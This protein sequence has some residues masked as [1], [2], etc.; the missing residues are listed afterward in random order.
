MIIYPAVDIKDGQCVRLKQGEFNQVK[1]YS[2]NPAEVALRWEAE[3]AQFL[4]VV[5]LDGA[6]SGQLKNLRAVEE[7]A[8]KVKI[9]FQLGGGIRNP[10][11]IKEAFEVG[12]SRIV[13]GTVLITQPELAKVVFKKYGSEKIVAG[14]DARRGKVAIKGW[15]EETEHQLLEIAKN[16][17]DLGI[18][19]LIFTDILSDGLQ[20]GLNLLAIENLA[21][22][23]KMFLIASGGVSSL[24]DIKALKNLEPLGLEGVIIGTAL[25]EKKFTL[26]EAIALGR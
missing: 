19:R 12:A 20:C 15:Q 23:T 1:V 8:R 5:D 25:Y 2:K 3:G 24:E 11:S 22:K 17:E 10:F 7:I 13:L 16:L 9:P 26:R 14:V 21:K 18:L 4:H 6:A